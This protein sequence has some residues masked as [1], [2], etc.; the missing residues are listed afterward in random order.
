MK[1]TAGALI[2]NSFIEISSQTGHLA[3]SAGVGVSSQG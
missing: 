2:G 3:G 1:T